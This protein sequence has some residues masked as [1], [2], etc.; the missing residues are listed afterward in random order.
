MSK[1]L[2]EEITQSYAD[3]L[4]TWELARRNYEA[5]GKIQRRGIRLPSAGKAGTRRSASDKECVEFFLQHNPARAVSTNAKTDAASIA[6]RPCFLCAKNRPA[7]QM[8]TEFPKGYE[9]L[10]NPYPIFPI[11]FTIVNREHRP[12]RRWPYEMVEFALAMPGM[13]AFFNG[14]RAGASLPDHEHF[15]AVLTSELPLMRR[16][17]ELH[18]PGREAIAASYDMD[19]DYPYLYYSA[20]IPADDAEGTEIIRSMHSL[21]SKDPDTGELTQDLMNTFVWVGDGGELRIAMVP[22]KRHRP[23]CYFAEGDERIVTSPGAVDVTGVLILPREEDYS[24]LAAEDLRQILADTC[25]E[26]TRPDED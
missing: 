16:V 26:N 7:E 8:V 10:I 12:Q 15:Q 6:A 13:C 5:L 11:H 18:R 17:E 19:P 21:A 2:M 3:Q 9:L 20:I 24:R 22:R 25:V 14:A 1:E 23:A 4:G